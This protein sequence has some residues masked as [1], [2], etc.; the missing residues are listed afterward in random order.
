MDTL[1]SHSVADT[2][3]LGERWG[4]AIASPILIGLSGD[5][6]AGKTQLVRGLARGLGSPARVHS[7]TFALIN[8]Y[9]G[10]RL[11]MHHLDL[12]RLN[13]REDV[14][15]AGLETYLTRPTGLV[16]VEWIEKWWADSAWTAR[17]NLRRVRLEV[18]EE[19]V[20]KICYEDIGA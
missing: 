16:V 1:I 15:G 2:V 17:F 12:Y 6:G 8:E 7:P 11:P 9:T 13:S 10:G 19:G 14:I 5:L 4:Q 18:L 3:A 20:R